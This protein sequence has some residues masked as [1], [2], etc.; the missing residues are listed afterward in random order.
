MGYF[1]H[2]CKA[3]NLMNIHFDC[4]RAV[5][6]I[7]VMPCYLDNRHKQYKRQYLKASAS[8]HPKLQY[9]D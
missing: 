5:C 7:S 3:L 2:V 9:N 8:A 1:L 6:L 4:R